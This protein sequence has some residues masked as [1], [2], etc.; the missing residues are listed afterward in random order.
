MRRPVEQNLWGKFLLTAHRQLSLWQCFLYSRCLLLQIIW[1][2]HQFKGNAVCHP[3]ITPKVSKAA[4]F[5]QRHIASKWQ[6]PELEPRLTPSF[7]TLLMISSI[8]RCKMTQKSGFVCID[9]PKRDGP[10]N[11]MCSGAYLRG[12]RSGKH[13]LSTEQILTKS[14]YMRSCLKKGTL[15]RDSETVSSRPA[16]DIQQDFLLCCLTGRP[17]GLQGTK[18]EWCPPGHMLSVVTK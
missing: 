4:W 8:C 10:H 5:A 16:W 17:R 18:W 1:S 11:E 12:L 13:H 15:I 14:S 2:H 3:H 7:H 9:S 6:E